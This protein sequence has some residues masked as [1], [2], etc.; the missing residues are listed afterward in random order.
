MANFTQEELEGKTLTGSD[1]GKIGKV[2]AVYLDAETEKP[3]WISVS[4]G[5]F[6]SKEALVPLAAVSHDGDNLKAPF[7]KNKVKDAPHHDPDVELSQQ[8]EVDL[9]TYYGVPYAGETVT[10]VGGPQTGYADTT[11]NTEGVRDVSGKNTDDAMTRSEE[12]L[13]V[14]TESVET[15]RVRLRKFIVTENVTRTVPVSHEEVRIVREPIT[16]ANRD[17][18]LSGADLSEEEA[19]ITLHGERAVVSKETVPVERVSLGKDTVTD[20]QEVSETLRKEQIDTDGI[21]DTRR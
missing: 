21:E 1:G 6:G 20:Q 18:A 4:T 15:G 5:L 9:F 17:A 16:D 3:E 14:G 7:D 8:Q 10:S 12:R 13:Q 2:N 11:A 19:E